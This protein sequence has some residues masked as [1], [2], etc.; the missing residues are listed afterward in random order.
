MNGFSYVGIL[1][2]QTKPATHYTDF[3]DDLST[4]ICFPDVFL[5]R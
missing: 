2:S 4:R 5:M 1:A 3:T